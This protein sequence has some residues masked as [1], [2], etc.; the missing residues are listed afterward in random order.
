[1]KDGDIHYMIETLREES[2]LWRVPA[3]TLI[4]E[5]SRD[6]LR[7]LISTMLSARTLDSTTAEVSR[8]LFAIAATP[9]DM[10]KM[11][12]DEM[13]KAIFPAGFYKTKARNI[14]EVCGAL[15]ERYESKVPDELDE[16]VKL[17]GVGR[18]TANLVLTLG[19]GKPGICVDTHVHRISNRW[20]YV[21]TKNPFE[22][23]MALREKLPKR[24]WIEYNDLLVAFGQHLCRPISPMCSTCPLERACDRAGV[25]KSR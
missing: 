3:V 10:L 17:K 4:A 1:M 20:G 23:E 5:S 6:P 14:L 15:V 19:Y 22:T 2:P 25:G 13:E 16:L 18:K 12:V 8:R 24:Y 9:R 21:E 11:S 7:V